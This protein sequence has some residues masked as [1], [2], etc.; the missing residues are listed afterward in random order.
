MQKFGTFFLN[1][2]KN[3]AKFDINHTK[4]LKIQNTHLFF[5][6]ITEKLIKKRRLMRSVPFSFL[7]VFGEFHIDQNSH[8]IFKKRRLICNRNTV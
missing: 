2:Y 5:S 7:E 8:R 4:I 6:P 1:F 3:K